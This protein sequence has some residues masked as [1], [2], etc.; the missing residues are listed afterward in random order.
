MV[1]AQSQWLIGLEG[2]NLSKDWN[3]INTI[4]SPEEIGKSNGLLYPPFVNPFYSHLFDHLSQGI[5]ILDSLFSYRGFYKHAWI[6]IDHQRGLRTRLVTHL[7]L[8]MRFQ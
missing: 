3:S 7:I 8:G 6:R 1:L 2:K 5:K 4:W